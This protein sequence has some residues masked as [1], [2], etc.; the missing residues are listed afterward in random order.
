MKQIDKLASLIRA[1][2]VDK[3]EEF[4]LLKD[5]RH[6]GDRF[7]KN[8]NLYKYIHQK[9]WKDS[10]RS[11]NY[12]SY[13]FVE[14]TEDITEYL[15]RLLRNSKLQFDKNIKG[16][17]YIG[18]SSQIVHDALNHAMYEIRLTCFGNGTELFTWEE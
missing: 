2:I 16:I 4:G 8:G 9:G 11:I 7:E 14:K 13:E 17:I 15:E 5:I 1:T 3:P 12:V 6:S 10:F 18:D